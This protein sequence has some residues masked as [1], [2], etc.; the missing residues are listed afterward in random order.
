MSCGCGGGGG[1]V[2]F[3]PTVRPS[4]VQNPPEQQQDQ[5]CPFTLD[6]LQGWLT[7]VQ[8]YRTNGFYVG[9]SITLRQLNIYL[10]VLKSAINYPTNFCWLATQLAEIQAFIMLLQSTGQCS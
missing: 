2:S 1:G 8:C 7:Q 3:T 9:T 5:S 6:M 10:G 4:F